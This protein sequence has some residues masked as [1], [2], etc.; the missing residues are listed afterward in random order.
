MDTQK[1]VFESLI[2]SFLL[3]NRTWEYFINWQ[4]VYQRTADVKKELNIL[5]SLCKSKN[6]D[7]E[8]RSILKKYPEVTKAFPT[9]LGIRDKQISVMDSNSLPEFNYIEFYF[10]EPPKT[11]EEVENFVLFFEKSGLKHLILNS[12]LTNLADYA[13]GVEVGLD[14][15]GRKN[16]GGSIMEDLVEIILKKVY[17]LDESSY[18][19]Q[20]SPSKAKQLWGIDL[21][22]D[23]ASRRPDFLIRK[24]QK[25]FWIEANFFSAGGSKLKSTCG[26]YKSLFD[27]CSSNNIEFIWITDGAGWKTALKPLEETFEHIDYIF[28][29]EMLK[30]GILKDLWN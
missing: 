30:D 11:K 26:E 1:K 29:L 12:G 4:K 20:G 17:Q 27:F 15:N 19:T 25:I 5:N 21:P 24:N 14:S 3:N 16:R 18:M 2:N 9:L 22:V 28:N 10:N 23:K 13:H 6:F 7:S 8:L